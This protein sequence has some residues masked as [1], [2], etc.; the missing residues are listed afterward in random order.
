MSDKTVVK[1]KNWPIRSINLDS[2]ETR[3]R[4]NK[5]LAWITSPVKYVF[6]SKKVVLFDK[7]FEVD[8]IQCD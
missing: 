6:D 3:L 4:L 8:F 7:I 5:Q 1:S 2:N